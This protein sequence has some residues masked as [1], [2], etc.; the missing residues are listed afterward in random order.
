MY[1]NS[2]TTAE[3]EWEEPQPPIPL[4]VAYSRETLSRGKLRHEHLSDFVETN[5]D[6]Q[7]AS[8]HPYQYIHAVPEAINDVPRELSCPPRR[9]VPSR[10]S[11][12][13][14]RGGHEPLLPSQVAQPGVRLPLKKYAGWCR[15]LR[16]TIFTIYGRLYMLVFLANLAVMIYRLCQPGI[17]DRPATLSTAVS[18]NLMI[19]VLIRQEHVVNFLFWSLGKTP[20][21]LP[22]RLRRM[23]AKLYHLGG[24]HSGCAVSAMLWFI[25]FNVAVEKMIRHSEY[26]AINTGIFFVTV[27]V[28]VLLA[29][30]LILSLPRFRAQYHN[31]WEQL[32]RFGGWLL[33]ALF[34]IQMFLFSAIQAGQD[35]VKSLAAAVVQS[36]TFY[37]L[38]IITVALVVPWLSLRKVPVTAEALSDHAIRLHFTHQKLD[39]CTS[40]R[41]TDHP[42]KEWH[43]FAAAPAAEGIG[44]SV[45]VSNAGDWTRRLI[46]NPP[47][48]LWTK[49]CPTRGALY[50]AQMFRRVLLVAT[51]SGIAPI[52]G[53][54]SIKNIEYRILWS[55]PDPVT[56]FSPHIIDLVKTADP[57]ALIWDTKKLG[58]PRLVEEA[59]QLYL[60]S[61]AE[62]VWIISNAAVTKKFVYGLESRGVPTFAPIFDS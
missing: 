61:G 54:I 10:S 41:F 31:I 44:Y 28:D 22:L 19:T 48:E 46:K 42:M 16:W 60:S 38:V 39:I 15:R 23:I 12:D 35:P 58:R 34:W 17:F 57:D 45:V 11:T 2:K 43:A 24:I 29:D 4:Q 59:Y 20:K 1:H 50:M 18:V 21:W 5:H 32:H 55:T 7:T 26:D 13:L 62:S 49:G 14:E 52:L 56:V 33:V 8:Q 36:P 30:I 47:T 6:R 25:L 9:P 3:Q 37:C 53:L 27:L 40:P 51:G